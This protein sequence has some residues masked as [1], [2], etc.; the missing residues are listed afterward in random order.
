[1][2]QSNTQSYGKAIAFSVF[3][4]G[5]FTISDAL[6]KFMAIDYEVIDILFWQA[7]FG[8]V[9]MLALS[10]FL[11]GARSIWTSERR[12]WHVA[13]GVL[14]ALN[15]SCSLIAISQVPLMDA[16]TIFFMTPFVTT[17]VF[18]I[19]LKE[20]IGKNSMAAILMGFVGGVTAFRPGFAELHPAYLYAVACLF[21]FS[22]ANMIVRLGGINGSK[23]LISLGFWPLL[24]V[25][26]WTF[27]YSGFSVP[28][29]GIWFLF[30]CAVIGVAYTTALITIAHSYSLAPA[31]EIAPYQYTQF[32]F[33]LIM[34]YL[35]FGAW[36]DGLKILGG[37][38]IMGSGAYLFHR[39]KTKQKLAAQ[40][41]SIS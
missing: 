12:K 20:K 3:A 15:T 33:A 24:F 1:M 34:G 28:Y 41:A 21:F 7:I 13:R 31:S 6:R 18:A 10:K 22:F 9:I 5:S 2:E 27:A 8:I 38:I 25:A 39:Q 4:Y 32:I 11:G 36:P 35:L 19:F 29:H 16:Y 17:L 37:C 26:M 40:N 23:S 30:V 14:M